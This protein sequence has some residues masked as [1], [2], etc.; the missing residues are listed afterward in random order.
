MAKALEELN[1]FR[2]SCRDSFLI[3]VA[4]ESTNQG[5]ASIVTVSVREADSAPQHSQ[6]DRSRVVYVV[7]ERQAAYHKI[8]EHATHSPQ[9]TGFAVTTRP[10]HKYLRSHVRR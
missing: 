8:V 1:F 4:E 3:L 5:L 7:C 2:K 10:T 6:A 9:V